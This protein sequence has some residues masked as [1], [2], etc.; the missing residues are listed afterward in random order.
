[1]QGTAPYTMSRPFLYSRF[2]ENIKSVHE[3]LKSI[4]SVPSQLQP[5]D[6]FSAVWAATVEPVLSLRLA[7]PC[8]RSAGRRM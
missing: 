6:C 2:A 4:A 1:M 8:P 7:V 3:T 5:F